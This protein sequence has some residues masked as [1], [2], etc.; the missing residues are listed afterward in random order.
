MLEELNMRRSDIAFGVAVV[1]IGYNF[2]PIRAQSGNVQ[3]PA[4][5]HNV[6]ILWFLHPEYLEV[7][8]SI[9]SLTVQNMGQ[10]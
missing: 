3:I 6:I 1:A 10:D 4:H 8:N 9:A 5:K 7:L 2:L